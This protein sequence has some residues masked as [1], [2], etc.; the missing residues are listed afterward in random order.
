ML[1]TLSLVVSAAGVLIQCPPDTDLH[2]PKQ[3]ALGSTCGG[4]CGVKGQC[5]NNFVC[6][7][8]CDLKKFPS[9]SFAIS[10]LGVPEPEGICVEKVDPDQKSFPGGSIQKDVCDDDVQ[11][12]AKKAVQMIDVQSNSLNSIQLV[13]V[14]VAQSQVVAGIKWTLTLAAG[15]SSCKKTKEYSLCETPVD[16]QQRDLYEVTLLDQAWMT[17]RYT[18][19]EFKILPRA[20]MANPNARDAHVDSKPSAGG[21]SGSSIGPAWTYDSSVEKPAGTK[22]MGSWTKAV[23]TPEQQARLGVDESG[24]KVVKLASTTTPASNIAQDEKAQ[25]TTQSALSPAAVGG[26]AFAAAVLAM[27]L[28]GFAIVARR[29]GTQLAS[30]RERT[31]HGET[32]EATV[33]ATSLDSPYERVI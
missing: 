16:E 30:M 25:A 8:P 26:I 17:P 23:Y 33:Q 6:Q 19:G 5:Q 4:V 2:S 13:Q 14:V 27:A 10:D 20:T 32:L 18:L 15:V 9:A 21:T 22:D 1:L 12:A 28:V 29:K 3:L 11:K 31:R 24:K 7:K